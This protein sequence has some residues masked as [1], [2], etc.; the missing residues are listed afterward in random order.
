MNSLQR[1][2][3]IVLV[4]G[5]SVWSAPAQNESDVAA[6]CFEFSGSAGIHN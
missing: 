4:I 6:A 5:V 1:V 3:L 2:F